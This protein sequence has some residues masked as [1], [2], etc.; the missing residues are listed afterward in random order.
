M[1]YADPQTAVAVLGSDGRQIE[2]N[3]DAVPPSLLNF[4]EGYRNA[5][6]RLR[7]QTT[8]REAA[9]VMHELP[10][11]PMAGQR[12]HRR[13]RPRDPR[14]A[15]TLAADRAASSPACSACCAA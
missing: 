4:R 8:P 1:T 12:P 2:G 10:T 9:L 6:I 7:G 5:L 14:H 13:R 15:R 3:L 11:R